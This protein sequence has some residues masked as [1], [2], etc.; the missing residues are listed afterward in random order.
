MEEDRCLTSFDTTQNIDNFLVF[1]KKLTF[2]RF[3]SRHNQKSVDL[4][5]LLQLYI[6]DVLGLYKELH[7][8]D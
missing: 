7:F 5:G 8:F 4:L 2:C 1:E 3:E 6:T